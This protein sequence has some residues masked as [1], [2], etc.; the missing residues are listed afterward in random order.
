MRVQPASTA[1]VMTALLVLEK[2]P[3]NKI[4]TV[5][6]RATLP[7]PSKLNL[8]EGEKYK[9]SDLLFALLLNSANDVSIVLAEAVAGSEA[10]FVRMMNSRA[11]ELGAKNTKFSNASGLPTRKI[12]QY[13]TPYDMY[14]IFREALRHPLFYSAIHHSYKTIYSTAGRRHDLRSHNKILFFT[15]W[16]GKVYGKTGYTRAAGSCFVGTVRKGDHALII[17]VFGCKR[18]WEDIKFIIEKY[19]GVDL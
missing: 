15:D 7:P 10:E 11:K 19:G 3:L 14:L 1:K 12:P 17:A 9:V 16:K 6:R 13:T 2:L 8:R 5:S 18:R 4:V